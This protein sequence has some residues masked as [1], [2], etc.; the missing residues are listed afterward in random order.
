MAAA[1][2]CIQ[3]QKGQLFIDFTNRVRHYYIVVALD[4]IPPTKQK[5]EVILVSF[6][7]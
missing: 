4:T 2:F 6:L 1:P 3:Y 5:L 7:L